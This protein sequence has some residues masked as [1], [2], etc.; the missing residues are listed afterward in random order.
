[1]MSCV[2]HLFHIILFFVHKNGFLD[3]VLCENAVWFCSTRWHAR[4]LRSLS[5]SQI[6]DLFQT[7]MSACIQ[8]HKPLSVYNSTCD[9]HVKEALG[10]LIWRIQ[11]R[12]TKHHC[13]Y[14]KFCIV[15]APWCTYTLPCT[16]NGW[17][18]TTQSQAHKLDI[19]LHPKCLTHFTY[20]KHS[21]SCFWYVCKYEWSLRPYIHTETSEALQAKTCWV[22]GMHTLNT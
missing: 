21:L 12:C 17:A 7:V 4:E 16:S 3:F 1:M 11:S 19:C 5:P 13:M 20:T 22:A 14:N 2:V 8:I 9:V 18:G 6:A 10:F 15:C